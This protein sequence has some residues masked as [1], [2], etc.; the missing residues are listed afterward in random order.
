MVFWVPKKAL[1]LGKPAT[2]K[3]QEFFHINARTG[4]GAATTVTSGFQPSMAM[5][6]QRSSP[7]NDWR[8]VYRAG[9]HLVPRTSSA[10]AAEAAGV[11]AF[12]SSGLNLGSSTNYNN[13]GSTYI[14]YLFASM[15]SAHI[16]LSYTGDGSASKTVACD[17]ESTP[18]MIIVKRRN[19]SGDWYIYHVD[20]GSGSAAYFNGFA[21]SFASTGVWNNSTPTSSSFDVAGNLN[22]S[23]AVYDVSVFANN[24]G[25]ISCGSYIGNGSAS[26]PSVVCGAGWKPQWLLFFRTDSFG[27]SWE[28]YDSVRSPTNPVDDTLAFNTSAAEET[29]TATGINFNSDGFQILTS[30]ANAN[31]SGSKYIY[32]AIREE[33]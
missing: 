24:P 1:M 26:G 18:G 15:P 13:S 5:I 8:F 6:K 11:T 4:T 31:A 32:M 12:T 14:D 23:G 29:N 27:W 22:I 25:A 3:P 7:S 10:E 19:S 9:Y 16:S 20:M 33:Y 30:G 2:V 28:V 21:S 17:L